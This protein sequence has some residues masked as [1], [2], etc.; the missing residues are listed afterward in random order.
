MAKTF[1][2]EYQAPGSK[3]GLTVNAVCKD[4]T[5]TE[6]VAQSGVMV[7]DAA[8]GKYYKDFV[9]DN[10]DW[11]IQISDDAGGKAIKHFSKPEFDTHGIAAV[12]DGI[13]AQLVIIDGK[14]DGITYPPMIG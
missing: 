2:V 6:V 9:V 3:T 1:R 5:H 13:S 11:T 7:E 8:T 4:E 12:V 10:A 14:L